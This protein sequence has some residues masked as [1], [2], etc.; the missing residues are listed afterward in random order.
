M[1]FLDSFVEL[2]CKLDVGEIPSLDVLKQLEI[3]GFMFSD[4]PDYS[5]DRLQAQPSMGPEPTL[6]MNY[7]VVVGRVLNRSDQDGLEEAMSP[8]GFGQPLLLFLVEEFA[9]LIRVG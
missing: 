5:P 6:P 4:I 9:G 7:E 3:P 8:D 2:P 1:A